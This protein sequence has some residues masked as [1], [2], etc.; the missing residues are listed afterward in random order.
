MEA[1]RS[2]EAGG[3][4]GWGVVGEPVYSPECPD[5]CLPEGGSWSCLT[6]RSSRLMQATLGPH[7]TPIT[8]TDWVAPC[9]H[10]LWQQGLWSQQD[11]VLGEGGRG[12]SQHLDRYAHCLVGTAC[13]P[14]TQIPDSSRVCD[15]PRSTSMMKYIPRAEGSPA[16]F[17]LPCP[18]HLGASPTNRTIL[19]ILKLPCHC[20]S[21]L[22]GHHPVF[23]T[24]TGAEG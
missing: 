7:P 19:R 18:G 9:P 11:V 16:K 14:D 12:S 1:Q 13:Y 23:T 17:L 2:P 6:T 3:R 20:S 24:E 5:I 8:D 22:V 4:P 15:G 10:Q 21:H